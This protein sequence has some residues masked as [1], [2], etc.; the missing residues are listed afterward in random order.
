MQLIQH[1]FRIQTWQTLM[2]ICL[3]FLSTYLCL[4]YNIVVELP[5]GLISVAIVFPIAFSINAAYQRREIALEAFASI[6]SHLLA[7]FLAHRDWLS[8]D[9]SEHVNR[10]QSLTIQILQ[11][12]QRHFHASSPEKT[13]ATEIYELFSA[14]SLSIEKLRSAGMSGSEISRINQYLR[15]LIVNFETM[16]NILAYRT[17]TSL[18]AYGTIFLSTFPILFG[19]YFAYLSSVSFSGCGF[20]VAE[21]YSLV[22]KSLDNIQ[23]LLE[24]PYDNIGADDV[25]LSSLQDYQ[26]FLMND[27][28]SNRSLKEDSLRETSSVS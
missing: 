28:G 18:K 9:N 24:N 5:S 16:E 20:L 15:V 23:D 13:S 4:R 1:F 25:N 10:I 6:K 14:V 12:L 17:P 21:V 8:G 3:S 26:A 27:L 11:S 2:V 7:M 22:L 19:P